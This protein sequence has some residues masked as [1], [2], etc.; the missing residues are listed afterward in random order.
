MFI[1]IDTENSLKLLGQQ[2]RRLRQ[3]RGDSQ[4]LF[5]FRIGVSVPTLRALENGCPTVS[6]GSFINAMVVFKR[7]EQIELVMYDQP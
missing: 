1:Y 4:K 2:I 6:L 7:L 5:A 3:K